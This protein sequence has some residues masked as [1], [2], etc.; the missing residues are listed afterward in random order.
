MYK[1]RDIQLKNSQVRKNLQIALVLSVLFHGSVLFFTFEQTYDANV[2]LFFAD[3]Y[4][5]DWFENWDY[6]WYTGFT[7]TSYPP[8]VHHVIALLSYAV[9][10]KFGF[11]IWSMIVCLMFVRGVFEFSKIWVDEETASWAAL[12]APFCFSFVEALHVF[13]QLPSIT[14]STF[15]LNALPEFY[16]YFKTHKKRYLMRGLSF[17]AITTTAHHVTTIFGMVFF[18][19]PT[20]GLAVIDRAVENVGSLKKLKF[21]HFIQ[22]VIKTLPRAIA[23]GIM[24]IAMIIT[25]VFPYWYW[26]KTDPIAQVSIPHGSRD[27]FIEVTS[28]GLAFF[29]IPWAMML[30]FLPFLF[31]KVLRKR[32]IFLGISVVLLFLFGTGGTTPLP[33]MLLGENAFNILTLDRFTYWGTLVS[34]P[35]WGLFIRELFVGRF[36][37]YLKEKW[38]SAVHYFV[39]GTFILGCVLFNIFIINLGYW[40]PLQPK[41]VDIVPIVNFL[42]TDQHDEWR[43]LTLGFGDQVAW[44]AANTTALS[45]DGN[46]HSARRLPE[47][48]S[49]AVERLENAK[50]LG[51]Q[52][53]GSL[54]Q[55]LT[56]PDK[57]NLKYI[58]SNDKF[59]DPML[60]FS[61][62]K[63]AG[64]LENNIMVWERPDVPK[65]PTLLPRKNI[66]RYQQLMWGGAAIGALLSALLIFILLPLFS[67]RRFGPDI[68]KDRFHLMQ[69][70]EKGK[71]NYWG[72]HLLWFLLMCAVF[73]LVAYKVYTHNT[74]RHS[75]ENLVKAY[76]DA[77]D[78]KHFQK[79]HDLFDPNSRPDFDQYML[80]LS[81]EDGVLS[82]YAKLNSIDLKIDDGERNNQKVATVE[83][84]WITALL[85][86]STSH[87]FD[88]IKRNNGWNLI[89]RGA[90]KK[91]PP[92]QLI[93]TPDIVFHNHGRR[94]ANTEQSFHEDILDRPLINILSARLVKKGGNYFVVGEIQ[95]VDNDP[96]FINIKAVLYDQFDKEIVSYN[97]KDEMSHILY[98]KETTPFKV[99][100]ESVAWDSSYDK[101]PASYDP[102]MVDPYEFLEEPV[103]FVVFATS[104]VEDG[105]TYKR[106]GLQNVSYSK[107]AQTIEGDFYNYGSEHVSIP[108]IL[109]SYSDYKKRIV[110][111]ERNYLSYGA[112]QQ[113]KEPF[114]IDYNSI[115]DVHI[116]KEGTNDNLFVNGGTIRKYAGLKLSTDWKRNG[117]INIKEEEC[118]DFIS[119]YINA[120]VGN[121]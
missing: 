37:Q 15:L 64:L 65:I 35:F 38:S 118:Y 108:Q 82:S 99:G 57:Y 88:L 33:K 114:T 23:F 6:R 11:L 2:H 36:K 96:A 77:I 119:L 97:A 80:E 83:A 117:Y 44:L 3:H 95:N 61:G 79:A 10:L 22:E 17:L 112:R 87:E 78:F 111:L 92:D 81:I 25:L 60:H 109:V 56:V 107:E 14:G 113:R 104:S 90:E 53:L 32:N 54:Q 71:K 110:W 29:L 31:M 4:A 26:S 8:L 73:T 40:R 55:F 16:Y 86:Y 20:I 116:I 75:P 39:I 105:F 19:A 5:R 41:K 47:L 102:D 59:Y 89:Y 72:I 42:H 115:D 67:K 103:N 94:E 106:V 18:I 21:T 85:G 51:F 34:M 28:S 76:F 84:H 30:F 7:V 45:V 101:I 43:Y 49:R 120:F 62:W 12:A 121:P 98:P 93:N 1:I 50:Y 24:A 48:T 68:N 74:A 9:G 66:P 63:R 69:L 13:G 46:Y 27:S 70:V 52:G 58:F 91:T 100:F